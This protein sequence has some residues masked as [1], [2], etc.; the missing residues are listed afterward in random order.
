MLE[1]IDKH[2]REL[3]PF[4]LDFLRGIIETIG[5]GPDEDFD[6]GDDEW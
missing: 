1:D 3:N 2:L 5:G 6:D 4:D